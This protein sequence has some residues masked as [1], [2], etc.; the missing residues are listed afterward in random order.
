[1]GSV[2]DFEEFFKNYAQKY[3]SPKLTTTGSVVPVVRTIKKT[4][5]N[6][7]APKLIKATVASIT[8]TVSLTASPTAA[9]TSPGMV[10]N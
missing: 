3:S 5:A 9:G 2:D 6:L 8:P 4:G 1:M 7:N 10:I